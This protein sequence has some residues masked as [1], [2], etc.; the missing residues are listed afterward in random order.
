MTLVLD[1][2]KE[3]HKDISSADDE[4]FDGDD[5]AEMAAAAEENKEEEIDEEIDEV[6]SDFADEEGEDL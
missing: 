6:D 2:T 5:G 3:K 4:V 1:Q